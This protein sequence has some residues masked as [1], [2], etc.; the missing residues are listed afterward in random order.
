MPKKFLHTAA[1]VPYHTALSYAIAAAYIAA[2][3]YQR[4]HLPSFRLHHAY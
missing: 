2:I 4:V 3:A 1:N